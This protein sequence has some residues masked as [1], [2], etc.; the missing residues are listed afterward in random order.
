MNQ[1]YSTNDRLDAYL[2]KVGMTGEPMSV[3]ANLREL[4]IETAERLELTRGDGDKVE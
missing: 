1:G 4:K 3:P 2:K